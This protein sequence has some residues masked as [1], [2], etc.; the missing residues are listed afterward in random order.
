MILI[1]RD[2]RPMIAL[3]LAPPGGGPGPAG[4]L[5]LLLPRPAALVDQAAAANVLPPAALRAYSAKFESELAVV[6]GLP[7]PIEG[8]ATVDQVGGIFRWDRDKGFGQQQVGYRQET[9][10]VPLPTSSFLYSGWVIPNLYGPELKTF[11]NESSEPTVSDH[12]D[13]QRAPR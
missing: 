4:R 10:G 9:T 7:G 11:G 5:Q 8:T 12:R 6:K 1:P 2:R 13:A 3:L